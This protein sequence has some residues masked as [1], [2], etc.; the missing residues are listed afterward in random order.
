[1]LARG[2]THLIGKSSE[3]LPVSIFG[4][5]KCLNPRSAGGRSKVW[6]YLAITRSCAR[7]AACSTVCESQPIASV[8]EKPPAEPGA[9]GKFDW[10]MGSD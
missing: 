9:V 10:Q 8:V 3:W 7:W 2:I 6:E 5:G 4:V 1:V